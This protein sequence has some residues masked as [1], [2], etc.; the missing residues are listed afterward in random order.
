MNSSKFHTIE[1]DVAI[2]KYRNEEDNR[3]SYKPC[4][5]VV[6]LHISIR[7]RVSFWHVL[8]TQDCSI[9]WGF[10]NRCIFGMISGN[11]TLRPRRTDDGSVR[12]KRARRPFGKYAVYNFRDAFKCLLSDYSLWLVFATFWW[13]KPHDTLPK[14]PKRVLVL[15]PD[16]LGDIVLI[17]PM[18]RV[19]RA[20]LPHANIVVC[21]KTAFVKVLDGNPYGVE[22][23]GVDLPWFNDQGIKAG[24]IIKAVMKL[25]DLRFDTAFDPRC[26]IRNV[27]LFFLAGIPR[28]I[29]SEC[30]GGSY[31]LT[32]VLKDEQNDDS[33]TRNLKQ[34]SVFGPVDDDGHLELWITERGEEE[35]MQFFSTSGLSGNTGYFMLFPFSAYSSKDWPARSYAKLIESLARK[36]SLCPVICCTYDEVV[37]ANEIV[38]LSGSNNIVLSTNLSVQGLVSLVARSHLVVGSCSAGVNIGAALKRPTVALYGPTHPDDIGTKRG[39]LG[40]FAAVKTPAE[41][42]GC[43]RLKRPTCRLIGGSTPQCMHR[44]EVDQVLEA[45]LR[46]AS[47]APLQAR[48]KVHKG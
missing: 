21:G 17:V 22:T 16:G 36:T 10:C 48:I 41:C 44:I 38:A 35:A 29:G 46:L 6:V 25:R 30:S 19:L 33:V 26:D 4:L 37:R 14:H 32:D 24:S 3:L 43:F 40:P 2:R 13:L 20:F 28:R 27:L 47:L 34:A 23:L 12:K 9:V 7:G 18:L 1:L 31:M 45:S 8:R 42:I 15:R 39:A 11:L 5:R